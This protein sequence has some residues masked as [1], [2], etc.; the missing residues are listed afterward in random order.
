MFTLNN[1]T[2]SAPAITDRQRRIERETRSARRAAKFN[3][4]T[5]AEIDARIDAGDH[6]EYRLGNIVESQ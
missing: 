5:L 6:V 4:E 2:E 3:G 1:I